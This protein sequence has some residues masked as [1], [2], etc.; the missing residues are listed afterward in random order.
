MIVYKNERFETMVLKTTVFKMTAFKATVF[1]TQTFLKT[2]VLFS[3]FGRRFHN[4]TINF[5][6]K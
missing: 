4:K 3:F 5:Q 2:I 1:K 6:K